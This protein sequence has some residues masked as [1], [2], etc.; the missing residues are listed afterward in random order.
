MEINKDQFEKL[1]T[2]GQQEARQKKTRQVELKSKWDALY[3][4]FNVK[5][6]PSQFPL[7]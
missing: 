3:R 2:A 1:T 6:E 4:K 5:E 7:V